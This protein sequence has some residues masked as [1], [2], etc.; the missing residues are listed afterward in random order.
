MDQVDDITPIG[1]TDEIIENLEQIHTQVIEKSMEK[2]TKV[3]ET[4][5]VNMLKEKAVDL[6]E[7]SRD[8]WADKE[9]EIRAQVSKVIGDVS[10]KEAF[11]DIHLLLKIPFH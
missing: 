9:E 7:S 2:I 11:D 10:L 3:I 4:L 8:L 1:N 5:V 6:N